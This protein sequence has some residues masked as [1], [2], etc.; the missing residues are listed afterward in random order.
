MLVNYEIVTRDYK[1]ETFIRQALKSHIS[2]C[3][4]YPNE[5]L[6]INIFFKYIKV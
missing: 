2:L 1:E 4:V 3:K 6:S 5:D